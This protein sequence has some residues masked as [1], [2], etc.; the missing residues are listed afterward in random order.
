MVTHSK[1]LFTII[2]FKNSFFICVSFFPVGVSH[3]YLIQ[4]CMKGTTVII[5][6][7]HL[8]L[9]MLVYYKYLFLFFLYLTLVYCITI[10][11]IVPQNPK[12]V[13]N[14]IPDRKKKL[15][16]FNYPYIYDTL[17]LTLTLNSIQR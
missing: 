5:I 13:G 8:K 9:P 17:K 7:Y 6:S 2:N 16:G 3:L 12:Q 14:K 15:S 11:L 10:A 4:I 1:R